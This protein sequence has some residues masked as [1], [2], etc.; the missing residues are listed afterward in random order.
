MRIHRIGAMFNRKDRKGIFDISRAKGYRD[1]VLS[2]PADPFISGTEV[3]RLR[4]VHLGG[5]S[6][7]VTDDEINRVVAGLQSWHTIRTAQRAAAG[8]R[9]QPHREVEAADESREG[10]CRNVPHKRRRLNRFACPR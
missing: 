6:V 9:T 10:Q 1:F 3:P 8:K 2:D 5:K 4:L 7:G